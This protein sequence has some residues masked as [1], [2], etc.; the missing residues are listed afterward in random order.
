MDEIL[1][2]DE[3]GG[4][5]EDTLLEDSEEDENEDTLLEDSEED[6][7]EDTLL[8]DSEED[9]N[10]DTIKEE[11]GDDHE[12][13]DTIIEASEDLEGRLAKCEKDIDMILNNLK[14]QGV[15]DERGEVRGMS[16]NYVVGKEQNESKKYKGIINTLTESEYRRL[17][18]FIK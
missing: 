14:K 8:E 16:D 15:L 13:E 18:R 3:N 9:E 6:E 4:V 5:D 10:E 11:E 17:K 1:E 2:M 7:N 12:S